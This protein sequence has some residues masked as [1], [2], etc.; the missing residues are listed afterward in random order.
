M[1]ENTDGGNQKPLVFPKTEDVSYKLLAEKVAEF[2]QE[3]NAREQCSRKRSLEAAIAIWPT[4]RKAL[5]EAGREV[6]LNNLADPVMPEWAD[7]PV[8]ALAHPYGKKPRTKAAAMKIAL[9]TG[10]G[11]WVTIGKLWLW[12]GGGGPIVERTLEMFGFNKKK[13]E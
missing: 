4:L 8:V 7:E 11:S 10:D 3:L 9:T 2:C 5:T 6:G 12:V 1:D 13:G